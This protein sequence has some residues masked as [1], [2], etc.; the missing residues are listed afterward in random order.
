[1]SIGQEESYSRQD[2]AESNTGAAGPTCLLA[3]EGAGRVNGEQSWQPR[4]VLRFVKALNTAAATVIVDT[5]EGEGYLKAMG[6][7]AGP[8]ALACEWVGTKL[9]RRLELQ[10][11]EFALV[12]VTEEDEIPL[13]SGHLAQPGPA[14]ITRRER[15]TSWGGG[16]RS[17]RQVANLQ[18]ISRLVLFDTWTLNCD[19]HFPDEEA[20]KPNRDN[21]FLSREGETSADKFILK[22]I[23]HTHC[24]TCGKDLTSRVGNIDRG[25]DERLYGLF[26]EFWEYMDR[27]DLRQAIDTLKGISKEEIAGIVGTIPREWDVS[28]TT[29]NEFTN[30]ISSRAAFVADSIERLVWAQG[31]FDFRSSG[32]QA[33]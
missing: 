26:P 14:F 4:T 28:T 17:L 25:K 33:Q 20:W 5:D 3:G 13:A 1:M 6:N 22:A 18:D 7:P 10:T 23:D 12:E 9:A 15:G 32:G 16:K 2:R 24:F 29:Q 31:Q 11:F 27:D 21:V 30:L 19:R 8:H